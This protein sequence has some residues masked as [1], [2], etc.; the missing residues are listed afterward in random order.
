MLLQS[1]GIDLLEAKLAVD[2]RLAPGTDAAAARRAV[3]TWVGKVR[4]RMPSD[5]STRTRVDL[6]LSTLYVAGPWNDH[7]PF[8]Y[9]LEDP[10]ARRTDNRLFAT[11][12]ATRRGNCVTMPLLVAVL[13]QRLGLSM[14][15]A[16]A[17]HHLFAKFRDDDGRWYNVEATSGGFKRDESY[18]RDTGI[19]QRAFEQGVYLRPLTA[20]Q[21]VVTL[22][23]DLADALMRRGDDDAA[24]ALAQLLIDAEPRDVDVMVRIGSLHARIIER[25]FHARWP[26]PADVPVALHAE[27]R[28]LNEANAAWFA[29]AEALGWTQPTAAS[30][31]AYLE[32]IEV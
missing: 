2:T 22:A 31:A 16:R 27:Y 10:F 3:D 4:A 20:R 17:P 12:L 29:K 18:V 32:S 24:L 25:R 6:L 21:A 14:S 9:D 19:S 13:G 11:Y 28:A 1:P 30:E 7:R 15:L 23:S 8:L 26:D 5:A